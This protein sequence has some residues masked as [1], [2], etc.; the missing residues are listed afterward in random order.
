MSTRLNSNIL[1]DNPAPHD[2]DK[3]V[4]TAL[5]DDG[6]MQYTFDDEKIPFSDGFNMC[7]GRETI[8][9]KLTFVYNISDERWN[10]IFRNGL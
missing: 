7:V 6:R 4:K 9:S 3:R 1:N 10:K 2:A 8:P 5:D